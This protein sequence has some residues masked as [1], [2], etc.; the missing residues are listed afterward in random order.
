MS[1][2]APKQLKFANLYLTKHENKL[3]IAQCYVKAGYKPISLLRA[4]T[5]ASKLLAKPYVKEY[6]EKVQSKAISNVEQQT[7][8]TKFR[9]I[10]EFEEIKNKCLRADPIR[11][12]KGL[13]TGEFRID[14]AGAL[15]A[16]ENIAKILG[17]YK[18]GEQQPQAIAINIL[19]KIFP[20]KELE[21]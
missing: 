2:L 18:E 14:S 12:E 10:K 1:K 20:A 7:G 4:Q 8:Y 16:V 21:N 15:R 6:I 11:D 9:V 17:H 5:Y 19:Q 13:P 3:T